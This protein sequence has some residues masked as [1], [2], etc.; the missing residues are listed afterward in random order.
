MTRLQGLVF[1][2]TKCPLCDIMKTWI[3]YIISMT[4]YKINMGLKI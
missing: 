2:F 4:N 3:N 1:Y